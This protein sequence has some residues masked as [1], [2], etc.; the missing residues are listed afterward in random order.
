MYLRYKSIRNCKF[1]ILLLVFSI[2]LGDFGLEDFFDDNRI[3]S[4]LVNVGFLLFCIEYV[5]IF[6]I[7]FYFIRKINKDKKKL[8]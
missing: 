4:L 5:I 3:F 6:E 7:D 1:F 8:N 2:F